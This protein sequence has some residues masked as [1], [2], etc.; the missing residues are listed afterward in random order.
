MGDQIASSFVSVGRLL[1]ETSALLGE[2]GEARSLFSQA[3]EVCQ[4]VR[5]RPEIALIRLAMAELLL[6]GPPDERDESQAHLDC[7]IGEFQQ[8]KMQPALERALSHKGLLKA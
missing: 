3:L 6:N 1:G 8:M 5:F 7:A 2:P 4:K